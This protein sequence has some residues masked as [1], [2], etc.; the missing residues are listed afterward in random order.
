MLTVV[1][2]SGVMLV[3]RCFCEVRMWNMKVQIYWV[4]E[5]AG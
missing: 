1:N 3:L 2:V 4:I 5:R